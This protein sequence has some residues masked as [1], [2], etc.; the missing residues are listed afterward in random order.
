MGPTA[1][2][3]ALDMGNKTGTHTYNVTLRRVGA[4]IVA[5]EKK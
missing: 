1:G 4:T 5:E 3:G 2:L